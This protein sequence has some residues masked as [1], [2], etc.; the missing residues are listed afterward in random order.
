M[1]EPSRSGT[2]WE[3]F[4]SLGLCPGEDIGTICPSVFFFP[5]SLDV[6]SFLCY[7]LTTMMHCQT[8]NPRPGLNEHGLKPPK[9]GAK[10]NLTLYKF[11]IPGTFVTAIQINTADCFESVARQWVTMRV[12]HKSRL[13]E[14]LRS[15]HPLEG[16][17]GGLCSLPPEVLC[18][19]VVHP[20]RHSV[21]LVCFCFHFFGFFS[22]LLLSF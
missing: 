7:A 4:R 12:H 19:P 21:L 17:P 2:Y 11:I 16:Y 1:A 13:R 10:V 20:G 5:G 3:E 6:S 8:R 9:P 18:L 15:H 22:C 14:G